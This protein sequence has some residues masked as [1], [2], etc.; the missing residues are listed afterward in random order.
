MSYL[1]Y[2]PEY[3]NITED[4]RMNYEAIEQILKGENENL[5]KR[6]EML[7][8][9]IYKLKSANKKYKEA[10][11]SQKIELQA[12]REQ[13]EAQ[14]RRADEMKEI[15]MNRLMSLEAKVIENG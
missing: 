15:I 10:C 14:K 5:K 1:E 13:C 4:A 8:S 2:Q 7:L 12:V 9:E 6:N 11:L 3:S